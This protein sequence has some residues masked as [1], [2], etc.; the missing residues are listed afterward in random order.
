MRAIRASAYALIKNSVLC[1]SYA[2]SLPA[3]YVYG[4]YCHVR[5]EFVAWEAIR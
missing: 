5:A 1:I 4:R 2:I 3:Y